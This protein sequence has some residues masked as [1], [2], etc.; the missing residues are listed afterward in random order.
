MGQFV[1]ERDDLKVVKIEQVSHGVD[2][3]VNDTVVAY[4]D[5]ASGDLHIEKGNL[6]ALEMEVVLEES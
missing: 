2:I 5:D 4:F 6:T 3:Y 1:I